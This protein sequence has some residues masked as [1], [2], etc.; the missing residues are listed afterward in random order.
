MPPRTSSA[1]LFTMNFLTFNAIY[2]VIGDEY[3][4]NT[5]VEDDGKLHSSNMYHSSSFKSS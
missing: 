5:L 4:F 3:K 1:L 2:K